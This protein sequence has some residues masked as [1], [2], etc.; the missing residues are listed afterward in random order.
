MANHDPTI[1]RTANN[2][3][4]PAIDLV[5]E[6][7]KC[8]G[9]LVTNV[10]QLSFAWQRFSPF[11]PEKALARLSHPLLRQRFLRGNVGT[12]VQDLVDQSQHTPSCRVDCQRI[13]H[14]V[15]AVVTVANL[16]HRLRDAEMLGKIEFRR[17]VQNQYGS[18]ASFNVSKRRYTMSRKNGLVRN[19]FAIH[20]PI[21]RL[22]VFRVVQFL[23]Q[24]SSRAA[25][26]Q[27][28]DRNKTVCSSK[29]AQLGMSKI[30]LAKALRRGG[31]PGASV[32]S[33]AGIRN[34][35][36]TINTS[37]QTGA[38]VATVSRANTLP[39]VLAELSAACPAS[40]KKLPTFTKKEKRFTDRA[41]DIRSLPSQKCGLT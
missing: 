20:Q 23:R 41:A 2:E 24:C 19:F 10:N 31:H 33:C 32:Y 27:V 11:Q 14:D 34:S 30:P 7:L 15:A 35:R 39:K 22:E 29:V 4:S 37:L 16:P 1:I 21:E 13:L 18:I 25:G 38:S 17:V 28:S 26:H 3:S 40:P 8:V 12:M 6:K 9:A 5:L 36:I